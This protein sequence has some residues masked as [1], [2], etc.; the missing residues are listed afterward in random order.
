MGLFEPNSDALLSVA[1]AY[2]GY[3]AI[4]RHPDLHANLSDPLNLRTCA[5]RTFAETFHAEARDVGLQCRRP[6]P[7]LNSLPN[8]LGDVLCRPT[9]QLFDGQGVLVVAEQFLPDA[10]LPDNFPLSGLSRSAGSRCPPSSPPPPPPLP[11]PF[12]LF[13][14]PLPPLPPPRPRPRRS[15]SPAPPSDPP[16]VPQAS[17]YLSST[18][19]GSFV[20]TGRPDG[21][22]SPRHRA[23]SSRFSCHTVQTPPIFV[24]A[25]EANAQNP[26]LPVLH[27]F[28]HGRPLQTQAVEGDG[29]QGTPN[30]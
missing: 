29:A 23:T 20:V 17:D 19:L 3:H 2:S 18:T 6:F 22:Y 5:V 16:P 4:R 10:L 30:V 1:C 12:R 15:P 14:P 13:L 27:E 9:D 21:V 26:F 8:M 11:S 25:S 7:L 24:R 28:G